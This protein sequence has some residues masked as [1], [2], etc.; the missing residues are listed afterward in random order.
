M[1]SLVLQREIR[2]PVKDVFEYQA[3]L[4]NA[5][6]WW[7]GLIDCR[8]VDREARCPAPGTRYAWRCAYLGWSINGEFTVLE[9]EPNR[10]FAYEVRNA[11]G[12]LRGRVVYE[13]DAL[14]DA[15]TRVRVLSSYEI[16]EAVATGPQERLIAERQTLEFAD[17]TLD[18]LQARLE[19]RRVPVPAARRGRRP[20]ID[21]AGR[22]VDAG[23]VT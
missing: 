17:D 11:L 6:E 14:G 4:S 5:P 12:E 3:E 23:S 8:R 22:E 20:P 9:R 7:P 16:S 10:R 1:T 21:A 19:G 13:F 18:T 15:R 2:R